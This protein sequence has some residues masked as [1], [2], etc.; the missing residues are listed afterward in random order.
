MNILFI[1]EI[2]TF[3]INGGEKIRSYSLI[4]MLD[5]LFDNVNVILT[6]KNNSDIN[7]FKK[8]YNLTNTNFLEYKK[9][10][11]SKLDIILKYLYK[12]KNLMS[13]IQSVNLKEIDLV[14]LDYYFLGQYISFF[15]KINIP[16]IYGTHNAQALLTLQE[17]TNSMLDII[18]KYINLIPQMIHEKIYFK[19]SNLLIT[20]SNEDKKYHSKLIDSEKIL[21]IPN[22]LDYDLYNSNEKLEKENYIVMTA[23]FNSFQNFFGIKWFLE[24]VWDEELDLKI[25]LKLVGKGSESLF[26]K[27]DFKQYKNIDVIG[28]V[29][30]INK[31]IKKASLS[32]VPLQHGSGSRLK[33]IE[34]M[35]LKT[36]LIS[37][38]LGV[39]GI[40]HNNSVLVASNANEFKTLILK[41]LS[42]TEQNKKLAN[43]AFKIF[44]K[45]YTIQSIENTF[46]SKISKLLKDKQ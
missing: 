43:E 23:N 18:K 13:L 22:L 40:E 20:V 17:E 35:A 19:D 10:K 38:K 32:I 26:E 45:K 8:F 25:N 28:P 36:T 24:N 46:K 2:S 16:V 4:K 3:P 34:A 12:D 7:S 31:F 11:K 6:N 1:T 37:T 14:F 39:E 5:N 42:N 27:I 30:D 29:E 21:V 15:Q 33:C 44:V 41:T 9:T